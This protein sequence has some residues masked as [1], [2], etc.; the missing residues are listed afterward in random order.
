LR[1]VVERISSRRQAAGGIS[2]IVDTEVAVAEKQVS[3]HFPSQLG[4]FRFH[5]FLDQ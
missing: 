1:Q 5:L 2:G 3:A 4:F